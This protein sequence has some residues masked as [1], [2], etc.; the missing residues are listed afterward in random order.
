MNLQIFYQD[1]TCVAVNKPAG[2]LVHR[3]EISRHETV[4]LMQTLR[5]QLGRRVYPVH[6][7]DRPTSGV[8]L[9]AF[10][11][12]S[13]KRLAQQFERRETEKTYWAVVRGWPQECGVIDYPLAEQLDALA[14]RLAA[15]D[16]PPQDAL[17]RYT[18]LAR[19]EMPFASSKQHAT[20]RYA[21]LSVQPETGRKHQIRRHL[22]HVFHPIVGDTT[23]GDLRQNRAVAAFSGCRRLMLHARSLSFNAADGRRMTVNAPPDE[24]WQTVCRL[25]GWEA[26]LKA[27]ADEAA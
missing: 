27:C 22:K 19:T 3:S 7:L 1:E 10:D 26:V 13:A 8:M 2:M 17:T 20:S 23:H 15:T 24:A 6:R 25:F 4:F 14:D 11:A 9:F 5:D 12:A 16:K 18:L 21:W